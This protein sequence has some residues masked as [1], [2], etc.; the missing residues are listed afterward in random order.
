MKAYVMS[1][2]SYHETP[3]WA[4]EE[5]KENKLEDLSNYYKLTSELLTTQQKLISEP[6]NK[7]LKEILNKILT[8][9]TAEEERL[10]SLYN[11]ELVSKFTSEELQN[12]ANK[13]NEF[14]NIR[15]ARIEAQKNRNE[16]IAEIQ[17]PIKDFAKDMLKKAE[18][19][20]NYSKNPDF[21]NKGF[22]MKIEDWKVA[23]YSSNWKRIKYFTIPTMNEDW[24]INNEENKERLEN[25][26]IGF[27]D[28]TRKYTNIKTY[29][30]IWEDNIKLF[31][32]NEKIAALDSEI[33]NHNKWILSN[34]E[35]NI[36]KLWDLPDWFDVSFNPETNHVEITKNNNVI[37]Y[38]T[39]NIKDTSGE[40]INT[41]KEN[42]QKNNPIVFKQWVKENIDKFA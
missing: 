40:I 2:A 35:K 22:D 13:L 10:K 15:L 36:T 18:I 17:K 9:R 1:V 31:E 12:Y 30:Q 41:E 32:N 16:K 5:Q 27:E 37:R 33:K 26:L 34:I 20:I 8:E 42:I 7:E 38:Y 19:L 29:A 4:V 11:P 24:S 25:P 39:P 6:W 3:G 14:Q 28:F 23:L 21:K